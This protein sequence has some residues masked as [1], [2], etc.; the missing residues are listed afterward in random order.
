MSLDAMDWVFQ[1]SPY[2]GELMLIHLAVADGVNDMCGNLFQIDEKAVA[3]MAHCS[4][5]KVQ[6]AMRRMIHDGFVE[7]VQD[8]NMPTDNSPLYRFIMPGNPPMDYFE[9][10]CIL[11]ETCHPFSLKLATYSC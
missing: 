2:K 3:K 6:R 8:R 1:K 4:V 5:E 11:A 7:V 9:M 10:L